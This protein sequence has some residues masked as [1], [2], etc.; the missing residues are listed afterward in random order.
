V[1]FDVPERAQHL[2]GLTF[3]TAEKR[4]VTGNVR[5]PGRF[6]VMPD[7]R[8]VYSAPL[9]GEVALKVRPPQRVA[10]GDTLFVLRAPEWQKLTAE[11]ASAETDLNLAN[12]EV[13]ALKN[14][15]A[16]LKEAGTR[17]A[18]LEMQLVVKEAERARAERAKQNAQD[19]ADALKPSDFSVA[20]HSFLCKARE[21]GV[22][23]R[24]PVENGA[25]VETG[26]EI[27]CVAQDKRLWF[28]ADGV[29]AEM[30]KVRGGQRGF[31]EPPG[32]ERGE[33][34]AGTIEL[35]FATDD[36]ARVHPVYL[37]P[38]ALPAWAA[39]G[40]AGVLTVVVEE[41]ADARVALPRACVVMDG[42]NS[43][44][45]MR[46]ATDA[47]G[48]R[49]LKVDVT[50]GATDGEWVEVEGLAEGAVVVLD[51]AYE[52]KLAA[53]SSGGQKKAAGHFHADGQF[54]EGTH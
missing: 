33:A 9:A 8:R 5:F 41:R 21:A 46:D 37:L 23:E 39:P 36:A 16:R 44:V 53:P 26:A 34:A 7:A 13:D 27:V 42:L 48:D 52:L 12:A 6:E 4:A 18:E 2:L 49:F 10:A 3:V 25:W 43:V 20:R 35:G 17:N 11:I 47:D 19:T 54:H 40:R 29:S 31:V 32:K 14:R 50:L 28:R 51:G 22:V 1:A 38:S 15:L 30:T 45:F 24:L